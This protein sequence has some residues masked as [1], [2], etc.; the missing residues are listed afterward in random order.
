M[1]W[2]DEQLRS[3]KEADDRGLDDSI[4]SIARAVMDTY[5]AKKAQN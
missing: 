1:S 4:Q 3:R 2:F 5:F